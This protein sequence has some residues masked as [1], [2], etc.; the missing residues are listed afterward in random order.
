MTPRNRLLAGNAALELVLL[1][2]LYVFLLYVVVAVGEYSQITTQLFHAT[3]YSTWTAVPPSPNAV[4]ATFFGHFE[5]RADLR[6]A[7]RTLVPVNFNGSRFPLATVPAGGGVE[8]EGCVAWGVVYHS[9]NL[10]HTLDNPLWGPTGSIPEMY[11]TQTKNLPFPASTQLKVVA[12]AN[13]ALS[14][15]T[16]QT[17]GSDTPPWLRRRYGSASVTYKPMG[18]EKLVGISQFS[19]SQTLLRTRTYAPWQHA[20]YQTPSP[21]SGKALDARLRWTWAT[22]R[23]FYLGS[24]NNHQMDALATLGYLE[25]APANVTASVPSFETNPA[26]APEGATTGEG[27]DDPGIQNPN[28]PVSPEQQAVMDAMAGLDSNDANEQIAAA[29]ELGDM[30]GQAAVA[31]DKLNDMANDPNQP[32]EVRQAAADAAAQIEADVQAG[33]NSGVTP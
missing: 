11:P 31:L 17:G 30:G 32:P 13:Q 28:V 2:P 19:T 7:P 20:P 5:P 29:E 33:Q 18:L 23:D 22:D 16:F 14:G 27:S 21:V 26:D 6:N 25:P 10:T 9:R 15:D 1:L 24:E 8:M 3:R 4:N 12:L